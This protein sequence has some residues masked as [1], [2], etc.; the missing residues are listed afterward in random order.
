MQSRWGVT[1]EP[2][3]VYKTK[4][5]NGVIEQDKYETMENTLAKKQSGMACVFTPKYTYGVLWSL[6]HKEA[7]EPSD[8]KHVC[9]TN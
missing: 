4:S 9:W 1:L 3:T 2:I 8:A 5:F 7:C 6:H